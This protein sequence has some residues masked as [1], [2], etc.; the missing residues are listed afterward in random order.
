VH[1]AIDE[2]ATTQAQVRINALMAKLRRGDHVNK[3]D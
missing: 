2:E 3:D 1:V